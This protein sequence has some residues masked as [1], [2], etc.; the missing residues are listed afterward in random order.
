M[1]FKALVLNMDYSPVSVCSVQ[2]AF[3]LIF[4]QKA[5]LI[6]E[7]NNHSLHTIDRSYPMPAVIKLNKY[8]QVPY[9]GVVLTREN[10]FR[11][12]NFTCQYCG[13]DKDLTLD[14]LVP[15]ARGGK[16]TWNNLVTAC[17]SCNSRKG[18]F[19][20]EEV[21]MRLNLKPYRPSYIMFLRDLSGHKYEEW[22]PYLNSKNTKVA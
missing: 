2:R 17:R 6:Q 13:T 14:H 3:L 19:R 12:D 7:N 18:D 20:P 8:V 11:R 9:K 16:T 5:E 4:L 22:L 10:I 1:K 21:G 15:K